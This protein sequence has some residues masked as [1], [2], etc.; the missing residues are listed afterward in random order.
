MLRNIKL[1]ALSEKQQERNGIYSQQEHETTFDTRRTPVVT[2][3][4]IKCRVQSL[5]QQDGKN[6][7][8]LKTIIKQ[9]SWSHSIIMHVSK[10]RLIH[11][12]FGTTIHFRSRT[13]PSPS[14]YPYTIHYPPTTCLFVYKTKIAPKI[15]TTPAMETPR[16][17]LSAALEDVLAGA[18]PVWDDPAVRKNKSQHDSSCTSGKWIRIRLLTASACTSSY[19]TR[20]A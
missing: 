8:R 11:F 16:R 15:P 1:L 19:S 3:K 20:L 7:K 18:E 12:S 5:V 2:T 10:R 6:Q 13:V 4:L 9:E 17:R 14:D